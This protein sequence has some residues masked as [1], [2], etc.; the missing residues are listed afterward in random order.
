MAD[1]VTSRCKAQNTKMTWLLKLPGGQAQNQQ[2]SR[3]GQRGREELVTEGLAGLMKDFDI[4]PLGNPQPERIFF[5]FLLSDLRSGE[6][7][8]EES[9]DQKQ[10]V[11]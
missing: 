8:E 6:E 5:F 11:Q 9:K 7:C 1:R 2:G 4:Y 3:Q 10:K